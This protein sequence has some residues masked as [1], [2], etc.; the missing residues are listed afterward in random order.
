MTRETVYIRTLDT[1]RNVDLSNET[2]WYFAGTDATLNRRDGQHITGR[3]QIKKEIIM[4]W[5]LK[6][7]G[8]KGL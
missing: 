1:L 7:K 4:H 3:K 6:T 2:H 5:K 8:I